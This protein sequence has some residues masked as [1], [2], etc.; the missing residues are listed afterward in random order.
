MSKTNGSG[1]Q[2]KA[3]Q[4]LASALQECFSVAASNA[5]QRYLAFE[6][7]MENRFDRQDETLRLFW[8]HI[9]GDPNKRLPIDD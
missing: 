4:N 5:E 1:R 9:K 7:R 2:K 8:R 3:I 6:E